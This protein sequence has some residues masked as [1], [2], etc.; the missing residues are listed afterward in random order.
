MAWCWR[1]GGAWLKMRCV[2][3]KP[4]SSES[5]S[6]GE[7]LYPLQIGWGRISQSLSLF[8]FGFAHLVM[9]KGYPIHL[10]CFLRRLPYLIK[11]FTWASPSVGTPCRAIHHEVRAWWYD[12]KG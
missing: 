8:S 5:P 2:F 3:S 11:G 9:V 10:L 4:Q 1:E 12:F 6:S 7:L